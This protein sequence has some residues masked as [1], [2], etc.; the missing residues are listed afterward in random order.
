VVDAL[1]VAMHD[2]R[3]SLKADLEA[4]GM[5]FTGKGAEDWHPHMTLAYLPEGSPD[6][7]LDRPVSIREPVSQ[8]ELSWAEGPSTNLRLGS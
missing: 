5:S 4:A 8:V 3:E 1:S 6:P 2:A 7:E